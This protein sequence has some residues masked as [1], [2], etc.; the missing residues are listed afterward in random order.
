MEWLKKF[1]DSLLDPD[2]RG[3]LLII[4]GALSAVIAAGWA[5]YTYEPNPSKPSYGIT[6]AEHEAALKRR[7]VEIHK[8]YAAS[9]PGSEQR[10]LLKKE[11]T[12]LKQKRIHPKESLQA[13]QKVYAGT[14]QLL[15]EKLSVQLSPDRIKQ[16]KKAIAEGNPTLAESLLQEVDASGVQQSADA[17]Y[18]LGLLAKDRVDYEKAWNALTRAAELAP[19][20]SLYLNGAGRIASTLGRYDVAIEYYNKALAIDLETYGPDHPKV[21]TLW[22]NL[23]GAWVSKGEYD[24]AIKYLDKALASDLKTYGLD[25]PKVAISWNNLGSAWKN[26]SDYRKA[27]EYFSKALAVFQKAGLEHKVRVVEKHIRDLPPKK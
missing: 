11:R 24:K 14:V 27:R 25:H 3:R 8:K 12:A 7:E 21:A 5:I 4:S 13:T 6:L 26:K 18:Q 15:E 2:H 20:N 23:G 9:A 19:D 1:W 17:S 16:A 22:N 10:A